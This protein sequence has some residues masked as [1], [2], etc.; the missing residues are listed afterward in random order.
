MLKGH[1]FKAK[2]QESPLTHGLE[3][4]AFSEVGALFSPTLSKPGQG[5]LWE[6][7]LASR[8]SRGERP[9]SETRGREAG[10]VSREEGGVGRDGDDTCVC[11]YESHYVTRN[12]MTI[13]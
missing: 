2:A 13:P 10:G 3:P 4:R 7:G 12:W 11:V 9:R 6:E 8:S 5:R 1:R